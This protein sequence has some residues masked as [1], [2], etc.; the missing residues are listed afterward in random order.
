MH[1]NELVLEKTAQGEVGV[2]TGAGEGMVVAGDGRRGPHAQVHGWRGRGGRR[3]QT[4]SVPAASTSTRESVIRTK[5]RILHQVK[6]IDGVNDRA[7]AKVERLVSG[8]PVVVVMLHLQVLKA[9]SVGGALVE[10]I[11]I[12]SVQ[13]YVGAA[14]AVAR[15]GWVIWNDE[16]FVIIS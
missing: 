11:E 8:M 12:A 7:V 13:R 9:H 3:G 5:I 1:L 10:L 16:V 6:L 2:C 4:P 14:E 15:V